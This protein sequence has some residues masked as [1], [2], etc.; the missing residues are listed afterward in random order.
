MKSI[1]QWCRSNRHESLKEQHRALCLKLRGHYH[2]YG[3]RTNI[4]MLEMV[5][6]HAE[7]AWR[8]WLSRRSN[9]SCIRWDVFARLQ[10]V[11]PLPKPR[12]YHAI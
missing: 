5:M 8:Y 4:T 10:Q 12:I 11:F 7:K 9:K 6:R 3:V 1:W 2:Y